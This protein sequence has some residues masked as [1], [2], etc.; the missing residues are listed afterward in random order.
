M[1]FLVESFLFLST[2]DLFHK[3]ARVK[4]MTNKQTEKGLQTSLGSFFLSL[5]TENIFSVLWLWR[6]SLQ[7]KEWKKS[8][9]QYHCYCKRVRVEQCIQG[10]V[11][12]PWFPHLFPLLAS[13]TI[14]LQQPYSYIISKMFSNC[15]NGLKTSLA[16][17]KRSAIQF[18]REGRP[19]FKKEKR[20][21]TEKIC[22]QAIW[23]GYHYYGHE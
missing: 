10:R 19:I 4:S 13:A 18:T 9:L 5:G 14:S 6:K 2:V 11:S 7:K 1:A 16:W 8:L 12:V 3:R 20:N 22:F 15:L 17:S 23:S 21:Q